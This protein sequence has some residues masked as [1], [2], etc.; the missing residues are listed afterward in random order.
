M[1]ERYVSI[2]NAALFQNAGRFPFKQ[3]L[4]AAEQC[5]QGRMIEVEV[6]GLSGADKYVFS[7][8]K[9]RIHAEKHDCGDACKCD[10]KWNI[11]REYLESVVQNAPEYIDNPAR[12]NWEWL[13]IH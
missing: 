6:L 4:E 5:S 10:G 9:G 12:L 11:S 3:I 2:C 7:L 8:A 13:Y 1:I